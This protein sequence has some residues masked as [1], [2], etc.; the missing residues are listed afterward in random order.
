MRRLEPPSLL[1]RWDQRSLVFFIGR[2]SRSSSWPLRFWLG[3]CWDYFLLVNRN[4][5]IMIFNIGLK[6]VRLVK[7]V[8]SAFGFDHFFYLGFALL[9]SREVKV[10]IGLCVRVLLLLN[11]STEHWL[12]FKISKVIW[13]NLLYFFL[14]LRWQIWAEVEVRELTGGWLIGLRVVMKYVS[15]ITYH[16]GLWFVKHAMSIWLTSHL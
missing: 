1:A 11:L 13:I 16:I 4:A 8:D 7:L 12:L 15:H 10:E 2:C 3:F 6:G 9:S 14:F 5:F